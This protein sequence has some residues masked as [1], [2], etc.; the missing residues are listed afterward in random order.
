MLVGRT[1]TSLDT[2]IAKLIVLMIMV[3]FTIGCFFL[4]FCLPLQSCNSADFQSPFILQGIV[5]STTP[6]VKSA[7]YSFSITLPHVK[8][9]E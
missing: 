7:C 3:P 6:A 8:I 9:C 4:S 1:I 2:L 5:T